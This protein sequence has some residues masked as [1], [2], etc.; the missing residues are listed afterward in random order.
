[1][2]N[3]NNCRAS[4][5]PVL[6]PLTLDRCIA[7]VYPLKHKVWVTPLTSYIMLAVQWVP[8]ILKTVYEV[9]L[10]KMGQNTVSSITF[11]IITT[12]YL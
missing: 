4:V 12:L 1:M 2:P 11:T 5:M 7:V 10:Y 8:C 6:I 3:S 9:V